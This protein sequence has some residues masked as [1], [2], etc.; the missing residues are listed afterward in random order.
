MAYENVI[1]HLFIV[2]VLWFVIYNILWS[3]VLL[4][5]KGL[6]NN[7]YTFIIF[8]ILVAFIFINPNVLE[9]YI[10]F[11]EFCKEQ[12]TNFYW[13]IYDLFLENIVKDLVKSFIKE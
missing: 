10:G 3:Y 13:F 4:L 6:F 2:G 11:L 1:T 8:L 9:Y 5:F 7:K 12:I